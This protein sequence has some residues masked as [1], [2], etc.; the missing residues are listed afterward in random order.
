MS[1]LSTVRPVVVVAALLVCSFHASTARADST[2]VLG[3]PREGGRRFYLGSSVF[4][5]ANLV[6]DD[7][8][9]WFFQLNGGYRLTP[10]DTLSIEAMTWRYYHPLGIPYGSSMGAAEEAYPGHIREYGAGVA[11][12][13]FLWMGLYTSLSAVPFLRQYFDTDGRK[14]QNGFQLFM[15]LRVGYHVRLFDRAFLEPSVAF[16]AWPISTNVPAAF[17][18]QDRKWPSYF[19]AEPGFHFGFEL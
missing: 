17:A 5:L 10:K 19:L 12:Q 8:P 4:M 2:T 11:Y 3:G 1:I 14:I 18:A 9:P 7:H 6:P 16:T 13:R 15:T